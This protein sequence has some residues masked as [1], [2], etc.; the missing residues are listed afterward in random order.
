LADKI[1]ATRSFIDGERKLVSVLCADVANYTVISEIFEQIID[2]ET[3]D[4]IQNCYAETRYSRTNVINSREWH[5]SCSKK[6]KMDER[7][8]LT[9]LSLRNSKKEKESKTLRSVATNQ[10]GRYSTGFYQGVFIR[11]QTVK[12]WCPWTK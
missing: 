5:M 9:I 7:D 2:E 4:I 11:Y 8:A 1:L 3:Q 6:E 10:S 12:G